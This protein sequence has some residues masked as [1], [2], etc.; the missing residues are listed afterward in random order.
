MATKV[1]EYRD[2][3]MDE[4]EVAK[5]EL[6]RK[7]FELRNAKQANKKVEQPHLLRDTKKEIARLLT[8]INEKR[9]EASSGQ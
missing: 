4:L 6:G 3:S 8:V 1:K 2:Q 7:L 5:D 9:R